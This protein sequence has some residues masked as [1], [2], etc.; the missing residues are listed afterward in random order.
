MNSYHL[1]VFLSV[2]RRLSYSRAAEELFISQPAVSR[3]V[4]ALEKEL[5]AKLLGQIGNRVYLTEAG[6]IVS[7]Y[8]RKLAFVEEEMKRALGELENMAR[9]YLR[10]GASST[11]GTYL[12]PPLVASYRRQYPGIEVTITVSHCGQVVAGVLQNELDL[13]FLGGT[14]SDPALETWPFVRDGLVLVAPPTH[15][16]ADRR[17]VTAEEMV[18][19]PFVLREQASCSRWMLEEELAPKGLRLRR[20][21]E[22][23]GSEAVK[24]AVAAGVG[25]AVVPEHSVESELKQGV[26][27]ALHV[28]GLSLE[29]Q[30]SVIAH[31]DV[32]LSAAAA[33]FLALLKNPAPGDESS[34]DP[35][36]EAGVRSRVS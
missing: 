34:L 30:M 22:L 5:G 33:A 25:I 31:R 18:Q 20:A 4:H 10:L 16:F 35:G 3:H 27:R 15:P 17:T 29:R 7:E 12:L 8:A 9:G 21:M 26:L 23:N 2:A 11:P 19:E 36:E 1:Q 6:K 28:D 32:R 14:P 13:G 24:R